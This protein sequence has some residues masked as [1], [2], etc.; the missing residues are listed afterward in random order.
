VFVFVDGEA[1]DFKTQEFKNVFGDSLIDFEWNPETEE[2]EELPQ[3]FEVSN[4]Q[5]T[6]R[7]LS[8][9]AVNDD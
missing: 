5:E 6:R 3:E 4:E 9:A 1:Y 7:E 8:Q 2:V